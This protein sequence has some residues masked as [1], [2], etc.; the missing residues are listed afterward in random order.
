MIESTYFIFT[1][2][3]EVNPNSKFSLV[4]IIRYWSISQTCFTFQYGIFLSAY[5]PN[6]GIYW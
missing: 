2:P 4:F 3:R 5:V 6:F 1:K